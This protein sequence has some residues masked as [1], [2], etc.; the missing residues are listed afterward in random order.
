MAEITAFSS[1]KEFLDA[2][3]KGISEGKTQLPEFQRGWVWDDSHIRSLLASISLSYPIGAVMMLET[4]NPDVKFKPRPVE[5]VELEQ[6]VNPDRYIL[7]GQQRLT[8]LFQ[9]VFLAKAVRTRDARGKA[10]DRLY[11][12]KMEAS[13]DPD[14]DREEAII[15]IP[16]DKK[17][18]NFRNEVLVDYS[19]ADSEYEALLFPL[20]Q[21]FHTYNWRAG[22]NKH[23]EHAPEKTKLFDDFEQNVLEAFRKYQ[24]PVILLK[25]QT[26]KDAVCQVFEK[27]NTGGVSLTVFE[28][29]TATF[30]AEEFDLREDWEGARSPTGKKVGDGR[31]DRLR[32]QPVLRGVT[33]P[34]FLSTVTLLSTWH[35]KQ[36]SPESAVSCKRADIL[37]LRLADYKQW[38]DRVTQGFESA[39]RFLMREKIFSSD[40]LPYSTQL[41][42]LA[43]IYVALGDKAESDAVRSKLTRWY[44]CG[45]FGELYGSTVE[46]RFAKDLPEVLAWVNGG[47]EPSTVQE[48]NFSP[49]RLHTL[50]TRRSAAY[51]GLSAILIRNG[52]LDFRT[53]DPIDLQLYFDDKIDVHHIFPQDYCR[54]RGI[55][56]RLYDSIVNKT[57]LSAK[58]NRIIGGRTPSEYLGRLSSSMG[59]DE[60]RLDEI[61]QSHLVDVAAMR[62]D[63]FTAHFEARQEALLQHIEQATG[64]RIARQAIDSDEDDEFNDNGQEEGNE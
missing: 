13:L 35:R 3:L 18:R 50:R 12:I 8:S 7:D 64:K 42:P 59:M 43:A 48:C 17:V 29:V 14:G 2:L 54:K 19:N 28:L 44:W 58:T 63:D 37:R 55:D 62:A 38:A 46:S 56:A 24:V 47:E 61:L 22:F 31:G 4:G 10:L 11:Y 34:D 32:K 45:V 60:G 49:G 41:V 9:S 15:G 57:P 52:G 26:P 39:A 23:W 20:N 36:S 16:A 30:A 53:G 21:V 6:G 33:A 27:V 1:D 40:Q 5:G 51:K 25:K